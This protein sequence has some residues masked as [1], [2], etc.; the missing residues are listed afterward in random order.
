MT[1]KAD[2]LLQRSVLQMQP[3]PA[4]PEMVSEWHS[5]LHRSTPRTS[6]TVQPLIV[7]SVPSFSNIKNR[8]LQNSNH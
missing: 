4:I 1:N 2:D 8:W 3:V 7:T 5:S 6:Q